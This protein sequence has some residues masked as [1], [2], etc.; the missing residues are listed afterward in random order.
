MDTIR[1]KRF[2]HLIICDDP[3]SGAGGIQNM[4]FNLALQ[5][6]S[7]GLEVIVSG[8]ISDTTLENK[9]IEIFRTK[10]PFRSKLSSDWRLL[11]M[12]FRLRFRYGREVVLYSMLINNV[13]IFRWLKP[14]L[15]WKCV[16]FLHGNETLRHLDKKPRTLDRNIRACLCVF[17][18][19]RYTKEIVEKIRSYPNVII[20]HPG[21]PVDLFKGYTGGSYRVER[22]L[23]GR[24]ILLMLGRLVRRKGHETVI[25]ALSRLAPKHPEFLLVVAGKGKFRSQIEKMVEDTGITE[26]VEMVGF[27]TEEEKFSLYDACDVYCM[28]SDISE[29]RYD[30]EG[31]GITFIEAAAMGKIAIGAD[32]GGIP[33]AI[34]N[35]KSGFLI[36]PGD[37]KHLEELLDE[38]LS[39][40]EEYKGMRDYARDRALRDFGWDKQAERI[41]TELDTRFSTA[42]SHNGVPEQT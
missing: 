21:I 1:L 10:K 36:K 31:F 25:N 5:L 4:A 40:P 20:V 14:V 39:N 22:G 18:N 23:D 6:K 27:V 28:P 16:S 19:S 41:L 7:R 42:S 15:G 34:E 37:H 3:S 35:G 33:D 9:G 26:H 38:I 30:V 11:V 13:K 17:A 29:K 12:F 8:R 32:C 24:K 2:R